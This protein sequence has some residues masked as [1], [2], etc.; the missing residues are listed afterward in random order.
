MKHRDS[1]VAYTVLGVAGIAGVVA[2]QVAAPDDS[3]KLLVIMVG[4]ITTILLKL[5]S[6]SGQLNGELDKR[7]EDAVE[8]ALEKWTRHPR[9]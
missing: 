3:E 2:L 5:N 6:V 7:I 8:R 4:L 9:A 1:L